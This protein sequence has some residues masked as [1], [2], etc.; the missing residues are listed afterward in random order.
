MLN[1]KYNTRFEGG[2]W[3]CDCPHYR[4]RGT[5]CRHILQNLLELRGKVDGVRDTSLDAYLQIISDPDSLNDRYQDILTAISELGCPSSDREIADYLGFTDP[6]KVRPRRY[7]LV[8]KFY[9]PFV[10]EKGRRIYK[11]TGKNV[12]IWG[13]TRQGE[14]LVKDLHEV[15]N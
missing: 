15:L 7:D 1:S 5:D 13:L 11:P 10:E 2:R 8:H 9:K 3:V 4:Y 12:F 14:L 6:N